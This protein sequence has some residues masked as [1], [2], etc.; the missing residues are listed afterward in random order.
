MLWRALYWLLGAASRSL[1]LLGGLWLLKE[2]TLGLCRRR[3]LL[4]GRS[5]LV[6]GGSSGIGF[7]T[8]RELAGRGAKVFIAC[9][10]Q[11]KVNETNI[12]TQEIKLQNSSKIL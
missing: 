5:V 8:C 9:R 2:V 7:E 4:T 12:K 1:C 6:T 3:D 10:N 11:Q